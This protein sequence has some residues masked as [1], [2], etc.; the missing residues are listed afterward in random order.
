MSTAMQASCILAR[1]LPELWLSVCSPRVAMTFTSGNFAARSPSTVLSAAGRQLVGAAALSMKERLRAG[2]SGA[3]LAG[4][5]LAAA[6]LAGSAAAGAGL[7]WG[8]AGLGERSGAG[9]LADAS[10]RAAGG[11]APG[12]SAGAAKARTGGASEALG[13]GAPGRATGAGEAAGGATAAVDTAAVALTG[14]GAAGAAGAGATA[15]GAAAGTAGRRLRRRSGRLL[16]RR[17]LWCGGELRRRRRPGSLCLQRAA[18]ALIGDEPDGRDEGERRGA[19]QIPGKRRP[20]P[21]G[22]QGVRAQLG[23]SGQLRQRS[24][25]PL[26]ALPPP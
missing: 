8:A 3:G 1:A 6:G 20:P 22:A 11:G 26:N 9:E 10:L 7:A 23:G 13:A 19:A 2:H 15:A 17:R 12:G 21:S 25:Y 14:A 24:R 16:R 18:L 5:G 4:A